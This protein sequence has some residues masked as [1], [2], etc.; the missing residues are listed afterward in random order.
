MGASTPVIKLNNDIRCPIIGLDVSQIRIEETL[1]QITLKD[2]IYQSIVKGIR[3]IVAE[4]ANEIIVGEAIN[5]ALNEHK[6]ER[7]DLFIVTKLEFEEK[8]NPEKA[9]RDSLER[10]NL[11]SNYV[12][13]YLDHWPSCINYNKPDKYR[14]I[15]VRETWEKMESLVN[16]KLTRS[17]GVSNYNI[18]NMLNIIS[19]CKIKP[20]VC[21]VEFH[22]YLFQ[23]DLKQFCDLENIQIFAYNPLTK[24]EYPKKI[25]L[26][27]KCEGY[28][29]APLNFLAQKY[30]L[31]RTKLIINWHMAL[32]IIPILGIKIKKPENKEN[33][34]VIVNNAIKKN[35]E[36]EK[37]EFD[38]KYIDFL[39]SF[40]ENQFRLND[41]FDIFGINI[42]A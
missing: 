8:E 16:Q 6:V 40:T 14:L 21:E 12:D 31:T 41:G 42:F 30:N 22:P 32:K 2:I 10:L 13:L 7:N 11:K 15:P 1:N 19:K 20:V 25:N 5:Q 35:L 37:I 18:V 4:P 26:Q 29:E 39:C 36:F 28:L 33:Q 34:M 23:K 27:K 38:Q 24:G 9:L 17:I 3:L